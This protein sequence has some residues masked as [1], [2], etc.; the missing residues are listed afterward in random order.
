MGAL[1][2]AQTAPYSR[3]RHPHP[4]TEGSP[5]LSHASSTT[6][7]V[8]PTTDGPCA[9]N[10]HEGDA[11]R[12]PQPINLL[13]SPTGSQP[14]TQ[15]RPGSQLTPTS[16]TSGSTSWA[17]L[18]FPTQHF[19]SG[20]CPLQHGLT[21]TSAPLRSPEPI[22]MGGPSACA[23]YSQCHPHEPL[24]LLM[25]DVKEGSRAVTEHAGCWF[26]FSSDTRGKCGSGCLGD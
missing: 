26:L 13:R 7:A 19:L 12:E 20:K 18:T 24:F 8:V 15:A 10:Y 2:N 5:P 23:C 16:V 9:D 11:T 3:A 6:H 22:L 1:Q 21:D 17:L 4:H 14:R 25:T